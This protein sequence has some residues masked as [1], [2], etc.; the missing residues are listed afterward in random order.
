MALAASTA[1]S[2]GSACTIWPVSSKASNAVEMV[3][4]TAPEKAAAP[5]GGRAREGAQARRQLHAKGKAAV[6]M[7]MGWGGNC[8]EA[9]H[10]PL[11]E[12]P[13]AWAW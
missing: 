5:A 1:I 7:A 11:L 13:Y 10:W 12:V 9:T 3:W 6:T 4:V 8:P 2:T